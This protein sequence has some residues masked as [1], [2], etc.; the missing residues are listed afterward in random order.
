MHIT[1]L[2]TQK[3]RTMPFAFD[4]ADADGIGAGGNSGIR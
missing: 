2:H 1:G 4:R 3:E